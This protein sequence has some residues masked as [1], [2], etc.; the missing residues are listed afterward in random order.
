MHGALTTIVALAVACGSSPPSE[1]INTCLA[2]DAIVQLTTIVNAMAAMNGSDGLTAAFSMMSDDVQVFAAG[3]DCPSGFGLPLGAM[4]SATCTPTACT[5]HVTTVD[6]CYSSTGTIDANSNV[7]TLSLGE[8]HGNC[9]A[10]PHGYAGVS[11][12]SS[13]ALNGAIV[14]GTVRTTQ[15]SGAVHPGTTP[16]SE[17][18]TTIEY[19]SVGLDAQGCPISGTLHATQTSKYVTPV[20]DIEGGATFGPACGQVR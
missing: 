7:L 13:F 3:P 1:P 2:A 8:S 20:V 6:Q 18:D 14:D 15:S 11:L 5:F 4:I 17:Y 9:F 19:H 16:L 12:D 10:D